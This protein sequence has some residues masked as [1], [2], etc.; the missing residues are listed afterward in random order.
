[1][2]S[3]K[4]YI[5]QVLVDILPEKEEEWNEWY[6]QVHIPDILR[7]PGFLSARRFRAFQGKGPRYKAIYELE[8][9]KALT[10]P[11]FNRARGWYQFASY[12]IDSRPTVYEE[13]FSAKP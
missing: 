8:D 10:T 9:E 11:E 13:I 2:N 1:M 6:N 7:C 4:K 3:K 12:V 5:L